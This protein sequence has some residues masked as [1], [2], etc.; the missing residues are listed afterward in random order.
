MCIASPHREEK[1]DR[2][3]FGVYWR[4]PKHDPPVNSYSWKCG[5]E[6]LA[7]KDLAEDVAVVVLRYMN[8]NTRGSLDREVERS[9]L[10]PS[11]LPEEWE[12]EKVT[13]K[14]INSQDWFG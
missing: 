9:A 10:S 5:L 4:D 6:E 2:N 1:N 12:G 3:S 8:G 13:V 11:Y 14:F 7:L